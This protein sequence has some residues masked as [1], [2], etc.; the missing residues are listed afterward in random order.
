MYLV[1]EKWASLASD[2]S[3]EIAYPIELDDSLE[4]YESALTEFLVAV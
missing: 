1:F 3:D 2:P 4:M